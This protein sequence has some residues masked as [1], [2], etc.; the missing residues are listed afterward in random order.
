MS[1]RAAAALEQMMESTITSGT[2]RKAFRKYEKDKV[3]ADLRIGG[4]T[5]SMGNPSNDVRYDWFVGYA[6]ERT[7]QKQV[8][9]AVMVGHEKLIGIRAGDYARRAMTYYFAAPPAVERAPMT[10]GAPFNGS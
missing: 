6:K 1:A 9:V 4:K 3:L 2:A 5:G 7:G 10:A 8:V